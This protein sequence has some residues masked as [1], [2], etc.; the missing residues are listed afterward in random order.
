MQ[1]LGVQ[2]LGA[3]ADHA[4]QGAL[5]LTALRCTRC[6]AECTEVYGG[7][8]RNKGMHTVHYTLYSCQQFQVEIELKLVHE[9]QKRETE[10]RR[11]VR[12]KEK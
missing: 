6:T 5:L 4:V 2:I 8:A 3:D 1:A 12:Y 7:S 9:R 10:K 11:V